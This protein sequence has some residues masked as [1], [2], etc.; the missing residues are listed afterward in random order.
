MQAVITLLWMSGILL[1][2]CLAIMLADQTGEPLSKPWLVAGWLA[3]A[4][5]IDGLTFAFCV[6]VARN[7]A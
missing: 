4:L 7:F 6:W 3:G 5:G 2:L 1:V